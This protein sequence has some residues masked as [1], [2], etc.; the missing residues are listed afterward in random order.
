MTLQVTMQAYIQSFNFYLIHI[1]AIVSLNVSFYFYKPLKPLL[2]IFKCQCGSRCV[3]TISPQL[4]T[5][6]PTWLMLHLLS[7]S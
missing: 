7:G 5:V 3:V 1:D 6:F 4:K 2:S